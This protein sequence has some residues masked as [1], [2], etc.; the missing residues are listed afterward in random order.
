[1]S[2]LFDELSQEELDEMHMHVGKMMLV[3][4]M[5]ASLMGHTKAAATIEGNYLCITGE[6]TR[7]HRLAKEYVN[8]FF[9]MSMKKICEKWYGNED[10]M[11]ERRRSVRVIA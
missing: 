9:K 10:E 2:G 6:E 1:M 11:F 7:T 5:V 4:P 8:D 3:L